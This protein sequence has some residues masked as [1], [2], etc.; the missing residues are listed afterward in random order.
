M[1][2]NDEGKP[3]EFF[4]LRMLADVARAR[5]RTLRQELTTAE[6]EYGQY[7]EQLQAVCPH[8]NITECPEH[9]KF[10]DGLGFPP[11]KIPVMR[12]CED[13]RLRHYVGVKSSPLF[14]G[15]AARTMEP[16]EFKKG[17]D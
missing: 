16:D 10:M 11:T 4:Q 12:R 17:N 8:L 1:S 15:P 9:E 6:M 7:R 2:D 14:Q 5:V 13:C 3:K